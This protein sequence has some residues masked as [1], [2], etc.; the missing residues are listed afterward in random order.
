MIKIEQ[1][2]SLSQ[3]TTLKAGGVADYFVV[4]KTELDLKAALT[5]AKS[6]KLK[7][8]VIGGGSNI[9]ASDEGYRGLVIKNKI[10]GLSYKEKGSAVS[11]SCGAGEILDVVVSKTARLGYWGLENLSSIPGTVGATP[12]QNVGAYGVEV[13]S[14]IVEVKAINI[15]TQEKKVFSK[16]ECKFNYR[17]SFFKTKL[18]MEWIIVAV[19]FKLS[20]KINPKLDYGELKILKSKTNLTPIQIRNKVIKIRAQKFPD[21]KMVGTAGSFFKNPIISAKK[22]KQLQ[23]KYPD[24]PGYIMDDGQ[25]KIS[26]GWALDNICQLRGYCKNGVCLYKNQALVLVNEKNSSAKEIKKFVS[27]V[28]N[29]VEKK[30]NILIEQEVRNI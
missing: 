23:A 5:F 15:F 29:E 18:G 25:V 13:S 4:V 10:T 12:V 9:L 2:V 1:N 16:N 8:L 24:L 26:L 7:V 3:H 27:F 21:W 14:L 20:K 30:I 19:V 28:I 6:E 11:L 22:F 17:D